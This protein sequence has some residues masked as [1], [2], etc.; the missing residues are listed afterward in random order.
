[1]ALTSKHD[2]DFAKIR[3]LAEEDTA[4]P[5]R[6][7]DL[8]VYVRTSLRER[9]LGFG[10]ALIVP[11]L[12]RV[13]LR[14]GVLRAFGLYWVTSNRDVRAV[15]SDHAAFNSPFGL[16][17]QQI[18]KGVT[19][20]LGDDSELHKRQ[21]DA[22]RHGMDKIDE[23]RDVR[24]P[25]RELV[26]ALLIDSGG[27]INVASDLIRTVIARMAADLLGC[28]VDNYKSFSDSLI[29][30]GTLLFADPYGRRYNRDEGLLA[31]RV[32]KPIIDECTRTSMRLSEDI[33]K[34]A[35]DKSAGAE[36]G[37][38]DAGP[39][40]PIRIMP[41]MAYGLRLH[42]RARE[43]A[44][45]TS[46]TEDHMRADLDAIG[47]GMTTA[48]AVTHNFVTGI[49]QTLGKK[50]QQFA[51]A[52]KL[53]REITQLRKAPDVDDDKAK[54]V[55]VEF[56]QLM[57]EASRFNPAISPGSF[58]VRTG[59]P[60]KD[61]N[62]PHHLR[63]IPYGSTVIVC[64]HAAMQDR[65]CT[66]HSCKNPG[67]F[68]RFRLKEEELPESL[69]FGH[70]L[71]HCLGA[72]QALAIASET[73]IALL[74]Q[75]NIRFKDKRPRVK[76]KGP[77]PDVLDMEFDP[78]IGALRQSQI[79]AA[80]PLE[81]TCALETAKE[82]LRRLQASPDFMRCIRETRIVHFAS[83]NVAALGKSG[84]ETPHV[85][86]E[87][88]VDG[89]Q[90]VALERIKSLIK[91]TPAACEALRPL[92]SL[93]APEVRR[94]ETDERTPADIFFDLV[95]ERAATLSPL[96]WGSTGLDFVG[97]GEFSVRQIEEEEALAEAVFDYLSD[98]G[99]VAADAVQNG[100]DQN[101][102][103][104][105][106][107]ASNDLEAGAVTAASLDENAAEAAPTLE[108]RHAEVDWATTFFQLTKRN[109][110][111]GNRKF[112]QLMARVPGRGPEFARARQ[113]SFR[114][115]QVSILTSKPVKILAAFWFI[116]PLVALFL[117]AFATWNG[118]VSFVVIWIAPILLLVTILAGLILRLR[119]LEMLETEDTRR[120][121]IERLRA[122]RASEERRGHA[123]SHITSVS[124]FKLGLF[125]RLTFSVAMIVIKTFA[126]M[127]FRPGFLT[128][129]ATIHYARW[130][131]LKGTDQ[132]IFQAN[133]DGSWESYL[134]DFITKV[135]QGQT[136]AWNNAEGFPS[137]RW[138]YFGGAEDGDKF[139]RWVR[140][141]QIETP[142]WY[143]H[144]KDLTIHQIHRN[145]LVRDGLA[146]ASDVADH[147]AWLKLFGS[148]PRNGTELE[149]DQVQSLVF[150]PYG[151]HELAACVPI[152]I[153]DAERTKAWLLSRLAE[154]SNIN[155]TNQALGAS[156]KIRIGDKD[157]A[158]P[159]LTFG[160]GEPGPGAL[161]IAFSAG[162]LSALELEDEPQSGLNSFP[163]AFLDGMSGRITALN[164]PERVL[165]HDEGWKTASTNTEFRSHA[166][167]MVYLQRPAEQACGN[168]EDMDVDWD[169]FFPVRDA[170]K[171]SSSNFF[172]AC[173]FECETPI[174]LSRPR[175]VQASI[176][177]FY[178][179]EGASQPVIKGTRAVV[180]RGTPAQDVLAPGEFI[181]GYEDLRGFIP[182]TIHVRDDFAARACLP[183]A[184]EPRPEPYPFFGDPAREHMFD[185]GRNG[186]FLVVRQLEHIKDGREDRFDT[187]ARDK[188]KQLAARM[189]D[190][191][192]EADQPGA[193]ELVDHWIGF[194]RAAD[195]HSGSLTGPRHLPV[196][197]SYR[198]YSS[199][200]PFLEEFIGAKL[201]G[202]WRDGS[203]LVRHPVLS[204]TALLRR[205]TF[206]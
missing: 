150:C 35:D 28:R 194:A 27:Q 105:E 99:Q 170:T 4:L 152:R 3:A 55:R 23:E 90:T 101:L 147:R 44:G 20:C 95:E 73:L 160:D 34:E 174:D 2:N 86:V 120:V 202:R 116:V 197:Q 146:R 60:L 21:T 39:D 46:Y 66:H 69:G 7:V 204:A 108:P 203:S 103:Q 92:I 127:W 31:G 49:L 171:T 206:Q 199:A 79:L 96:P 155:S 145:A 142:F 70:G 85:L 137:T 97:T 76:T 52:V 187:F 184:S 126:V 131:R 51:T 168:T 132:L 193:K 177:G 133:Y 151:R 176:G 117:G 88:N 172:E 65:T 5:R 17:M 149:H 59:E 50:P 29:A 141:Q 36:T 54:A 11:I 167:L 114:Q 57:L 72:P 19:F 32:M 186:S 37:E 53:A 62:A 18:T 200:L 30:I 191:P 110:I 40:K 173:G 93:L 189:Y 119:R 190:A 201:I 140:N 183:L 166:V 157:F 134:E 136:L 188:A 58:R 169:K 12:M 182:P 68:N 13:L 175:G 10:G 25:V 185:L 164:D 6:P 111:A 89:R 143:A 45:D 125:R 61:K 84:K 94:S 43:E 158:R 165:W 112:E 159:V 154:A 38:T 123:Q 42:K 102:E 179:R 135:H 196:H 71:H 56:E 91:D 148:V 178:F 48:F 78:E 107:A 77:V 81:P 109:I 41:G 9:L 1:M 138:L 47:Y 22:L 8:N 163:S 192:L 153:T 156:G 15:L 113:I 181:L 87:L 33:L 104:S 24:A 26:D 67:H 14:F 75:P 82:T 121:E 129:F 63:K 98:D 100:T 161:F 128:D 162:G 198:I 80:L 64:T 115:Y 195:H 139:K 180:K 124:P 144:F 16:E 74:S 83:M 130:V 118:F 205:R 122:I 106:Q